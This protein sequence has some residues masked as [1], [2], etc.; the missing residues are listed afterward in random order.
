MIINNPSS[1]SKGGD[2]YMLKV[3]DIISLNDNYDVVIDM[4]TDEIH[5][6][7]T[8]LYEGKLYDTP[9]ELLD[10]IVVETAYMVTKDKPVIT[11]E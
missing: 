8:T 11:V 5:V 7:A 4:Y 10:R 3:K 6:T 2:D 1:F 9:E